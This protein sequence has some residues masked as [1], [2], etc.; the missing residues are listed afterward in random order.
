[1]NQG[2]KDY[3]QWTTPFGFV[4]HQRMHET[5]DP[6]VRLFTGHYGYKPMTD[7]LIKV[8]KPTDEIAWPRPNTRPKRTMR[9]SLP[10]NLIHSY[11]AGLIHGSL[12]YGYFQWYEKED[13]E[14]VVAGHSY[15][16]DKL[17]P[18][19]YDEPLH[20][21]RYPIVTI[22][23][24]FACHANYVDDLRTTLKWNFIQ[25]YGMFDPLNRFLYELEV[26]KIPPTQHDD[27]KWGRLA[28]IFT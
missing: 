18:L 19:D 21:P 13:G 5:Q 20:E 23:D 11:D 3:L 1:M 9:Q 22:H 14:L 2:R 28:P 15:H 24:A 25:M 4:V 7:A 27:V 6:Q 16:D 10:P 26:S 17:W 8:R 12:V